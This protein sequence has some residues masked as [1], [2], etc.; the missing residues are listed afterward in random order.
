MS[1]NPTG[2]PAGNDG[3][4]GASAQEGHLAPD[5]SPAAFRKWGRTLSKFKQLDVQKRMT[6]AMKPTAIG[7]SKG[8]FFDFGGLAVRWKVEGSASE[9]RFSVVHHPIAP[10]AL[11]A[12]LHYHHNEDEYSYVLKGSLGALLDDEVIIVEP[13]TWVFKPRGQWHTF[14]NAGDEP[15]EIIEVISPAGFENY[16]REVAD[17]WGDVS[18]FAEINHK[19]SLDM[20][21]ASVPRLC[22]RFG[23]TFP[24][25]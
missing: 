14:W 22:E 20:D 1:R 2:L 25:L 13:G 17:A 9:K 7:S 12:P 3:S 16:F 10:R 24:K 21:F 23:V 8:D 19:Y 4:S 6:Q 18:K 5:V 11:A 15:C